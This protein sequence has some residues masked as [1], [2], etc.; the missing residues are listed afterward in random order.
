MTSYTEMMAQAQA[1]M[2]QAQEVRRQE[3]PSVIA[4]IHKKM[5]AYNISLE[6]LGRARERRAYKAT[7][8]VDAKFRGPEGQTWTGRGRKPLWYIQAHEQGFTDNDLLISAQDGQGA[9]A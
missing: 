5:E 7:G 1:I 2:A 8:K 6:D 9:H 3:I 4:E